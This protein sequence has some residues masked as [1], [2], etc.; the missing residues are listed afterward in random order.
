MSERD[1][2]YSSSDGGVTTT[3]VQIGST[4]TRPSSI[5]ML[6]AQFPQT[7]DESY[8]W[9][10][11]AFPMNKVKDDGPVWMYNSYDSTTGQRGVNV[12]YKKRIL[13][14]KRSRSER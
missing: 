13:T 14:I 2:I 8:T 7:T 1:I 6:L 3:T 5:D 11:Q 12:E 9:D 10:L 4:E